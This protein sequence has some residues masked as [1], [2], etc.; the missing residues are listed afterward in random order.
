MQCRKS[1]FELDF[2]FF[3]CLKPYTNFT[4]KVL[5]PK[6]LSHL[7]PKSTI[8]LKYVLLQKYA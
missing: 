1:S 4:K 6:A 3:K 5:G 7:R 8:S 2:I